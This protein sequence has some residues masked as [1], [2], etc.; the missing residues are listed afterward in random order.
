M[1][2]LRAIAAIPMTGVMPG[3]VHGK[4]PRLVL[5]DPKTLFIEESYQRNL[6]ERSIKLI[7]RIVAGWDWCKMKPPICAEADGKMFVIDGQHTSIAAA[8]HGSIAKIPVLLVDSL[9]TQDRAA[10]FI[11]HNRDRVAM[12][13]SQLYYAAL[14]SG[15]EIAVAIDQAC[16]KAGVTIVK[17]PPANGIFK[18]GETIAVSTIRE[19]VANKGAAGGARIL[20]ILA[21]AYRF[22][23]SSG[24]IK[25][26]YSLLYDKDWR[27]SFEDDDLVTTI[28]SRPVDV[29][30]A[31]AESTVRKGMKM[32]LWRAI[33]IAWFKSVPKKRKAAS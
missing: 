21:D 7:R 24:E 32:P 27:G 11:G 13:S 12:T 16:K 29:W 33:A 30:A 26:V 31:H 20:K 19:V 9:T 1:S 8:S 25:A 17:S 3:K 15:D 6:S 14:E 22:P 23:L 4:M 5:V 2:K 28:R 18:E 10:A